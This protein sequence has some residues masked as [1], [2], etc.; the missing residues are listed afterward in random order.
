MLCIGSSHSTQSSYWTQAGPSNAAFEA[1]TAY[2]G[3]YDHHY[4]QYPL[5]S[6]MNSQ[7]FDQPGYTED[8]SSNYAQFRRKF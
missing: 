4:E 2:Y 7:T 8:S 5:M 1:P 3:A 6:P